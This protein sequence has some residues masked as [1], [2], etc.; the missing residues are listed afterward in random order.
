MI[1]TFGVIGDDEVDSQTLS[2]E[3]RTDDKEIVI[4]QDQLA[5][6]LPEWLADLE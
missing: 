5:A 2:L 6:D 4:K 1:P 3:A